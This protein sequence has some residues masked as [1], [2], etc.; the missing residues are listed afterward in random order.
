LC[1][2][3]HPFL[4]E[5]H[6]F[7]SDGDTVWHLLAEFGDAT[8]LNALTNFIKIHRGVKTSKTRQRGRDASNSGRHSSKAIA[9]L[10][11]VNLPN[12]L[13]QTPLM[14]AAY[15]GRDDVLVFLLKQ[16]AD[17]WAADR[18]GRRT[19]LHYACMKGY[20]ACVRAILDNLNPEDKERDGVKYVDVA[21]ASGFTPLHFAVGFN[22]MPVIRTLL[23]FEASIEAF[24]MFDAGEFWISCVTKS[25]ALHVAAVSNRIG[26][27]RAILQ[28]YVSS[29]TLHP[30]FL[31]VFLTI[32][33]C[34]RLRIRIYLTF[35]T[36]VAGATRKA[37]LP[38][39]SQR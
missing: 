23:S 31:I 35:R 14:F 8:L 9:I 29:L 17:P 25:T 30:A 24:N 18:C 37:E 12:R 15:H 21:S 16:G 20:A 3:N 39:T 28:H 22:C 38:R 27:A 7:A 5:F 4:L 32:I 13:K 33:S 19:A 2:A 11:L 1:L 26:C 34:I 6:T 10:N 36:L